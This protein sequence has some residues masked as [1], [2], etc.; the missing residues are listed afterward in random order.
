MHI[1]FHPLRISRRPLAENVSHSTQQSNAASVD[2]SS[3]T[4][5]V[6]VRM[7]TLRPSESVPPNIRL[8]EDIL[9]SLN[10]IP[11]V[12]ARS[13]T[14][15]PSE[16]VL[17]NTI[18]SMLCSHPQ[19]LPR[20]QG[21]KNILRTRLGKVDSP[22]TDIMSK[23]IDDLNEAALRCTGNST[24]EDFLDSQTLTGQAIALQQYA[25]STYAL[26]ALL[27]KYEDA[28][29]ICEVAPECLSESNVAVVYDSAEQ[30]PLER[31]YEFLTEGNLRRE[32]LERAVKGGRTDAKYTLGLETNDKNLL[33]R[34][35][36]EGNLDAQFEYGKRCPRNEQ[37]EEILGAAKQGHADAQDYIGV[38]YHTGQGVA[39]NFAEAFKWR[40]KAA[41][42]G[43]V[44]SQNSLGVM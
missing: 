14:P 22:I 32:L 16:S 33:R 13:P 10:S 25:R 30:T 43:H 17:Q 40:R 28:L 1:G 21:G 39:K 23:T 36:R 35:A 7:P 31:S 4:P 8:P 6:Q 29:K 11:P 34:A 42:Q 3:S 18:T 26:I 19:L 37:F 20:L 24:D 27:K 41:E 38:M 44:S 15:R 9:H 2:S 5:P 12:Q